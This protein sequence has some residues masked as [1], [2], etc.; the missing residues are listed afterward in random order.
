MRAGLITA[1]IVAFP[2]LIALMA[3]RTGPGGFLLLIAAGGI[4]AVAII[5]SISRGAR[6]TCPQCGRSNPPNALFCAQCGRAL[7]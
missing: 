1:I 7:S 2:L 6:R 5:A 4:A 3:T